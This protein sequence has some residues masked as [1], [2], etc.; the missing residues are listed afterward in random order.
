[1]RLAAGTL[2]TQVGNL[3]ARSVVRTLRQPASFVPALVFPMLLL[4]VNAGGL[5]S[6]TNIPGFPTESYLDF[7]LAFSFMQG[8]TFATINAGTDLAKDIQTGFLSRLSLTPM[9][10][11]ALLAGHLAGAVGMGLVQ[12]VFYLVVGL[13]F[14]VA[15]AGGVGGALVLLLLA[16]LIAAGFGAIGAML[17]LRTG[18]GEAIQGMFPLIFVLLFLSSMALPRNLIESDWFRVIAT[19]NPVSYLIEGMRSLIVE[20]WN[21]QALGLAFAIS[22]T[23]LVVGLAGAAV[24]LRKRLAR[25]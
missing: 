23:I 3:A 11:G 7:F 25:T 24:A 17:A 9:R 16:V 18:S 6:A 15:I 19:V 22:A 12:A 2:P 1:M 20:G 10:G 4:A 13:A 14:G 5:A 8:A 21:G